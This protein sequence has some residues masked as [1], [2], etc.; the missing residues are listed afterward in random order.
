QVREISADIHRLSYKLHPSKLDHLGLAAAVRSLCKELT[1][2]GTLRVD[3]QQKG[4][5]ANVSKDVKLCI[6]RIAQEALRNCSRHSGAASAQVVLTQTGE[7]IRL[8]VSDNGCGFD[9][10][11]ELIKKG[12]GFISMRERLRLVDGKLEIYSQPSRGT[13][14]EVSVPLKRGHRQGGERG[15]GAALTLGLR[16]MA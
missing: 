14:I 10:D 1:D 2:S 4:V 8:S 7:A 16:A 9:A 13:R 15:L 12:L 3:L 6:F 11:S 5:R